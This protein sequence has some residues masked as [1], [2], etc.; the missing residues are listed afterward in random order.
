MVRFYELSFFVLQEV[1]LFSMTLSWCMLGSHNIQII[2]EMTNT[3]LLLYFC[4]TEAAHAWI[5]LHPN[6]PYTD[7]LPLKVEEGLCQLVAFLFLNDGLDPIELSS[8]LSSDGDEEAD[9]SIPSD[10][11]LRQYFRFCIETDEGVYGEGFRLAARAYAKM[12]MQEL[13]Y[14]VALHHDFPPL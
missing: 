4:S 13:L 7:P 10:E 9:D 11:K 1:L 5:K 6:F 12:G 14:Y 3:R 8:H 2:L